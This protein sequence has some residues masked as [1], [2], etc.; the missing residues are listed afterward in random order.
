MNSCTR[1]L[2]LALLLSL[3]AAYASAGE[4]YALVIG[5]GAYRYLTPLENP[6]RDALAVADKLHGL[7]FRLLDAQGRPMP[8]PAPLLDLDMAQFTYAVQAFAERARGAEIAFVYYAG[9]GMQI[10]G[11]SQLLPVDTPLP[12]VQRD[13]RLSMLSRF[14]QSLDAILEDLDGQAELTL[15]VFDACREIPNLEQQMR[16]LSRSTGGTGSHRGLARLAGSGR[17]RVV[18][19]AGGFGQLVSDGAGTEHSPY[20]ALLLE[21]LDDPGDPVERVFLAIAHELGRMSGGQDPE[22][23]IQG[24][25]PGRFFL[26]GRGG[27]EQAPAS[28]PIQPP[29]PSPPLIPQ[30]SE[31]NLDLV[32]WQSA[33]RCG[34]TQCLREY[35]DK[36]PAG[37]FSGLARARLASQSSRPEADSSRSAP[38]K[39]FAR[40]RGL[41]PHGDNYLSMR[42]GPGGEYREIDRIYNNGTRVEVLGQS[43]KWRKVRHRGNTGWSH[44]GYL[45][46]PRAE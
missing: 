12:D 40:T 23:L 26:A 11:R 32:Y 17:S 7:G 8:V 16:S 10:D 6:K 39:L 30:P 42:T 38:P 13:K 5:N 43:G 29:I 28:P 14:S 21:H 1:R 20:T 27:T 24:V 33:E 45:T 37:E 36:Y 31:P 19:F 44:A 2:V 4:R 15:A 25:E 34:T 3:A 41:D 22:V 18:A 9:H 46:E 35:L